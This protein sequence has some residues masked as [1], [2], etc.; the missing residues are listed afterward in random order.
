MFRVL[1]ILSVLMIGGCT[2]KEVASMPKKIMVSPVAGEWYPDTKAGLRAE[3]EGV[4]S[5]LA[6]DRRQGVCAVLVPHAG[7]Q[8]SGRT[9]AQALMSVDPAGLKRIVVIGPSHH[10]AMRNVLSI[11]DAEVFRT[12]LGDLPCDV[13]FA[14]KLRKL[15]F[16]ISNPGAHDREHSDQIQLPLI[17]T[18]LATNLPVVCMVS[19][20]WDYAH[21]VP[22][23]AALRK[24]LDDGTL[25]VIS[26]DFTHYGDNYDY[27]PFTKDVEANLR[28]LDMGV[29]GLF[30]KKDLKG[31]IR[32][33]DETGATVCGRNPLALLLAMLPKDAEVRQVAYETSGHLMHDTQNSVSYVSAI[34][35]GK[36]SREAPAWAVEAEKPAEKIS[37]DGCK[38]LL[39]LARSVIG[40]ALKRDV[41][42][43]A[44]L[45]SA[46][47]EGELRSV[48]GGFVTLTIG[49]E[50]RGCIGEIF[51]SRPIW[52]VVG[53]QALNAAFEDP[54]FSPLTTNEFKEISIEI[55]VLT[56]P[57][58]IGSWKDIVIG[59]HGVVLEE[60][61]SS[62]VFLPQV[63][64]EQGWDCP[65]M[66]KHL[67]LKAGLSED[68]WKAADAGFMVF[69]AQV[70]HE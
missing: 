15:P 65:T 62:A 70:F 54:R 30:A 7:Y 64:P 16:V 20:E 67:S 18:C 12:P 23:A 43:A 52:K 13:E 5:G 41:K 51:P 45:I 42:G 3:L 60:G 22:A 25:V 34:V 48:R 37:G 24:L 19:G 59:K 49:G 46:M 63:A 26:S 33:L 58:A 11:P 44:S 35:L 29:F 1:A 6:V 21:I 9:A 57:H 66:L 2:A 39:A 68:A 28:K 47:P 56:P 32:F 55:S 4:T 38:R 36:W 31:F 27:V 8:F 53:E 40:A 17:Q 69:E 14:D 50:L 10:V 61:G